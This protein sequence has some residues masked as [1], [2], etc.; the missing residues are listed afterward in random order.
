MR[1]WRGHGSRECQ[2]EDE[3]MTGRLC[4]HAGPCGVFEVSLAVPSSCGKATHLFQRVL[5]PEERKVIALVVVM[6]HVP[7]SPQ[8]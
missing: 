5:D 6:V 3:E 1:P 2:A 7:L 4:R 8:L